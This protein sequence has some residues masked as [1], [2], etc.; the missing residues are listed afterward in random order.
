MNRE[1]Q[2]FIIEDCGDGSVEAIEWFT[3]AKKAQRQAR[4]VAKGLRHEDH[5]ILVCK[6]LTEYEL[7]KQ[8]KVVKGAPMVLREEA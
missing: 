3:D 4:H 8:G 1:E 5:T 6:L 7:T 2:Y